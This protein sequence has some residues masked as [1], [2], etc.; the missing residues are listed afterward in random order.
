MG[1]FSDIFEDSSENYGQFI[2]IISPRKSSQRAEIRPKIFLLE[3]PLCHHILT[4]EKSLKSHMTHTH[5][6]KYLY[7]KIN[8]E[9]VN[10]FAFIRDR[11]ESIDVV[12]IGHE[13]AKINLESN[14]KSSSIE[15]SDRVNLK[16]YL[17]NK[18]TGKIVMDI[19][20]DNIKRNFTVYCSS[21][22]DFQNK[23]IDKKALEILFIPL[24]LGE[25]PDFGGFQKIL[26]ENSNLSPEYRYACGLHDYA[27]AFNMAKQRNQEAKCHFESAYSFLLPF[28]TFTAITARR[29]LALRMNFFSFLLDCRGN[30]RFAVANHFF[31]SPYNSENDIS[32]SEKVDS[33]LFECGVY[34]D[35]FTDMFLTALNAYYCNEFGMLKV[36]CDRLQSVIHE[37]DQNN[38]DK[39]TLLQ[40]RMARKCGLTKETNDEYQMLVHHPLFYSE[41]QEVLSGAK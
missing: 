4:S 6:N 13:K 3:C 20:A 29:V 21:L 5:A 41:S 38:F 18:D 36:Y 16:K 39:L 1:I 2:D 31:N 11:I 9:V 24:D 23:E 22:P 25:S 10:N 37:N 19:S 33:K 28:K 40:A 32:A 14:N 26:K 27:L 15:F 8:G 17:N 35:E 12:L 34:I 30:S 7:V